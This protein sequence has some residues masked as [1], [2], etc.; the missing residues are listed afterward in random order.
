MTGRRLEGARL[1]GTSGGEEAVNHMA[2][3]RQTVAE[4]Q[5]ERSLTTKA[6]VPGTNVQEQPSH[7]SRT[8]ARLRLG[9][10]RMPTLGVVALLVALVLVPVLG[11]SDSTLLLLANVAMYTALGANWNL[12]SGYTG[13]IDFGHAVFFGLGGYTTAILMTHYELPLVATFPVALLLAAI[14]GVVIGLPLL[15]VRGIYFSIAML[16]AFLGAR[17]IARLLPITNGGSGLTIPPWTAEN[18]RMYFYYGFLALAIIG[19]GLLAW[20]RRCQLGSSLLAVREDEEGAAARGVNTTAVKLTAFVIAGSL[21]SLVGALWAYQNTFVDPE[22]LF[23]EELLLYIA[24]VVIVG[25]LGTVWG[26]VVGAVTV[27]IVRDVLAANLVQLHLLILGIFLVTVVLLMPAGIVGSAGHG[28]FRTQ[29]QRYL[30]RMRV[31]LGMERREEQED[32]Q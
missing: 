4:R 32:A 9:P 23:R 28:G 27:V 26:P 29:R 13:Y 7:G 31:W 10:V 17:E 2:D 18:G 20:V 11:P 6:Q 15:R 22:I 14:F 25:G 16:G 1:D 5:D 12:I 30:R 19:V 3:N 24:L 21:T 8:G